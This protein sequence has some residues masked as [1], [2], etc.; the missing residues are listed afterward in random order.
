LDEQPDGNYTS[1]F[2]N[3]L[4]HAKAIARATLSNGQMRLGES[5]QLA[6]SER[7]LWERL[8]DLHAFAVQHDAPFTEY[9]K[10]VRLTLA[11]LEDPKDLAWFLAS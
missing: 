4:E 7:E 10:L 1:N 3:R 11:P 2:L 5:Y 6:A 9:L 8:G